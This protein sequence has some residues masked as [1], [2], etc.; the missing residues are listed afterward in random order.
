M[1]RPEQGIQRAIIQFIRTKYPHV[2]VFHIP[3]GG[4]RGLVEASIFKGLGVLAGVY[5]LCILWKAQGGFGKCG[6]LEIKSTT[7]R[8]TTHQKSFSRRLDD[9]HIKHAC[10]SSVNEAE[11]MLKDWGLVGR[12]LMGALNEVNGN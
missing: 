10:I 12:N 1:Q 2:V 7:G 3:N 8:L 9:L 5:D 4:R 11:Q 6:F